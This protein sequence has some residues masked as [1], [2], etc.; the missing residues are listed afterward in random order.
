MPPSLYC[1]KTGKKYE[2]KDEMLKLR[3][4]NES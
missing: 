3:R 4:I 1:V 2:S